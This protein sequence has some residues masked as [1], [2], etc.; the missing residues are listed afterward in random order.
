MA[1]KTAK[2]LA[3]NFQKTLFKMQ[4]LLS[5]REKTRLVSIVIL[6]PFAAQ[7]EISEQVTAQ[8]G[9]TTNH[10]TKLQTF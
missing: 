10:E 6:R 3:F 5:I 1:Q 4:S 9:E 7:R 8:R 2:T